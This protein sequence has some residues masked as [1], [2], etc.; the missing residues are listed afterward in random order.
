[1]N[2]FLKG[3]SIVLGCAFVICAVLATT[4]VCYVATH[5]KD[6]ARISGAIW[7]LPE[8]ANRLPKMG[9]GDS[10]TRFAPIEGGTGYGI[11][12]QQTGFWIF[13]VYEHGPSFAGVK[14]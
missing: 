1:M 4:T 10:I 5:Q 9:P 14:K 11:V 2:P 6:Q 12:R 7:I 3:I 13:P 8:D